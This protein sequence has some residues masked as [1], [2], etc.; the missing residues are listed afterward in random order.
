MGHPNAALVRRGYE[1]FGRRDMDTLAELFADDLTW[2]STASNT[3]FAGDFKGQ[4]EVFAMLATIPQEV[5][6]LDQEIHDIVAGDD[7]TIA[8]V[9]NHVE[10]KGRSAVL[11]AVHIFH[12]DDGL[13]TEVWIVDASPAKTAAF[14][15]D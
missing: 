14:Y 7:H 15:A 8:I 5:D 3:P 4:K 13:V 11:D 1:A 10:R 9:R 12:V 2:H 6:R